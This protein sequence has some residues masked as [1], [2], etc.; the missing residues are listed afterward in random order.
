MFYGRIPPANTLACMQ[1]GFRRACRS[2]TPESKAERCFYLDL[3]RRHP[4]CCIKVISDCS[5][6][7]NWRDI[8]SQAGRVPII[9]AAP[10][11]GASLVQT[12]PKDV[13][14]HVRSVLPE[15]HRCH[16]RD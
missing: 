1:P 16:R 2:H 10:D 15:C 8:S 11:A 4:R 9:M 3:W 13:H 6:V 14:S 7:S 5:V 12:T